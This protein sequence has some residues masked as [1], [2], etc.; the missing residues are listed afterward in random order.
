MNK[1]STMNLL[2]DT[3]SD[4]T[5]LLTIQEVAVSLGVDYTTVR[6]WIRLGLLE[7]ILLPHVGPRQHYR[8]ARG[9]LEHLL[10]KHASS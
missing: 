2:P 10:S 6:R 4:A 1:P 9:T 7:A 8:I 3:S 5:D